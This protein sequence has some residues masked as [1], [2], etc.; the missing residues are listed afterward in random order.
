KVGLTA[1]YEGHGLG[2]SIQR[3]Y[4]NLWQRKALTV[5]T[6]F[7][8]SYPLSSFEDEKATDE[9]IRETALYASGNGFGDDFL[10][11]GGLGFVV[12]SAAGIGAS[13]MRE[14]YTGARGEV[15]KGIQLA[16]D[17]QLRSVL[18]KMAR[19]G[20]RIQHVLAGDAAIDTIL[21]IL[22]DI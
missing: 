20:L 8:I 12:D 3:A 2:K 18:F 11:L 14:P 10:K 22:S 4:L 9:L 6:Y 1:I 19:A 16:S 13:L 5:R 21:Q 17:D 7:V 15:W